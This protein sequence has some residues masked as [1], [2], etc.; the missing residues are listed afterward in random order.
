MN[1]LP[2]YLVSSK[3][4]F[5]DP[6]STQ[7]GSHPEKLGIKLNKPESRVIPQNYIL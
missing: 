7:N 1:P 2:R 4:N 6:T 5:V 3:L